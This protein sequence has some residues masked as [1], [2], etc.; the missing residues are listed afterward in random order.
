MRESLD[1][2]LEASLPNGIEV[3]WRDGIAFFRDDLK[4]SLDPIGII[5][6]HQGASEVTPDR[7]FDIIGDDSTSGMAF[8]PKPDE[9][10]TVNVQGLH[11]ESEQ[12]F[13]Q[14]VHAAI[15]RPCRERNRLPS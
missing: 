3:F 13:N 6:V 2:D 11:G 10:D 15:H 5:D 9:R 1:I 14:S 4:G 8:R 12:L 7:P